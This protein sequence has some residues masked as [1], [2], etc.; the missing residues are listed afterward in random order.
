MEI[1]KEL[2]ERWLAETKRIYD[3][4]PM[5]SWEACE[6]AAWQKIS[7][8]VEQNKLWLYSKVGIDV[9]IDSCVDPQ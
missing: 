3:S 1:S 4:I 2:E 5:L 6:M 9:A 8:E 7:D